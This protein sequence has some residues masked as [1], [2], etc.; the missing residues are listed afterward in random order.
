MEVCDLNTLS[1]ELE[2]AVRLLVITYGTYW[3][4]VTS[5]GHCLGNL[6]QL[7]TLMT[8]SVQTVLS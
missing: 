6:K 8:G 5:I 2:G 7:Y 1:G 3:R 4:C